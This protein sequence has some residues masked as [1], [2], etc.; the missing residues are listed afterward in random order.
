MPQNALNMF[1]MNQVGNPA[2][3]GRSNGVNAARNA[4]RHSLEGNMY[5]GNEDNRESQRP[6]AASRPTSL[7]S[8]YSTNDVPTVKDDGFDPAITPPKTHADFAN[9]GRTPTNAVNCRQTRGSPERDDPKLLN[10]QPPPTSLQASAAPFGPQISTNASN[11][12]VPG[13]AAPTQLGSVPNSFYGYGIQPYLGNPMQMNGQVPNYNPPGPYGGYPPYNNF[14][15]SEPPARTANARRS[16][17]GESNQLSRFA[18]F[19]LEHYRGELYSLCKDQ[20]GCRYL[21]RKLEERTPEHVQMIFDETY[22]HVVE[23]MTDPFGNYLCQKLLEYSNDDQRTALINSAAPELVK[24][25]LNQ[26]G[27]R[28]LQKMIEFIST[29]EQTRTVIRAL[30]NHVVELVQDLNGNHVIQKCLNRL[31]AQ[32]AQFVYD[33]VGM[34]CVVVGTHRHGCCVLQ[35]CIDHA[36]GDQRARLIAQITSNAF[37][38]VQDPFGNYVVQYILDLAEPHFTEPLCQ[39]FRSHIPALS[40]QKFSS[41]VIEKCLRT[42]DGNMR[43]MLVDEMLAGNE[44]EKML[45]DSFANYVVQTAMDFSDTETRA[46]IVDA[47]RPILP[48]IR[49]TPPGRRIAGK[50]MASEG[51][52]RGSSAATNGQVPPNEM[53]SAQLPGP[54]HGAPKQLMY[55]QSPFGPPGPAIGPQFGHQNF[56]PA[57]GSSSGSNAS[58]GGASDN[59]TGNI[60]TPTALQSNG[61]FAAAQAPMYS[62]F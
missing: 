20:H 56:A 57:G 44:L 19:P 26:H 4:A 58:S 37:S 6:S 50:I 54:L 42:A 61:N 45:R 23:L 1:R 31:S 62:Y 51:S 7:Q 39:S 28:A 5:Y 43:H 36:S 14:R 13:S 59:S 21:Q 8:S 52:G 9:L 38:L 60:Y 33:A 49:Q 22:V 12:M 53:N 35:R 18:N 32:D 27:T 29:S 15:V 34:N 11:P 41:N 25:A 17:D 3:D 16:A 24:I 47:I 55:K 46:R 10:S 40:K 30:E 2:S 48:T